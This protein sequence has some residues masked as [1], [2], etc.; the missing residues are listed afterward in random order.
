MFITCFEDGFIN[1]F[2]FQKCDLVNSIYENFSTN[3]TLLFSSIKEINNC[4]HCIIVQKDKY[5]YL[6]SN[7]YI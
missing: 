3:N 2:I 5:L 7:N 4:I 1:L 6:V